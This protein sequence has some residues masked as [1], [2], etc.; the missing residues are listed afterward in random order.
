[1]IEKR[2]MRWKVA[3]RAPRSRRRPGLRRLRFRAR[4]VMAAEVFSRHD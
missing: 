4:P 1:M 3:L 2:E